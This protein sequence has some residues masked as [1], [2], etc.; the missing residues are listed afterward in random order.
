M[1]SKLG[2]LL[3]ICLVLFPLT[4]L[5]LDGDQPANRPAERAQDD[6]SAAQNPWFDH[7][8]RCCTVCTTGCVVC[9]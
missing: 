5:P 2:V 7:V 1:M 9:C 6:T 4:A 8:K 3:T